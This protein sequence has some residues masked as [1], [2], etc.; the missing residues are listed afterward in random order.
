MDGNAF[1]WNQSDYVRIQAFSC[2]NGAKSTA[3]QVLRER[4]VESEI[5]FNDRLVSTGRNS[6]PP[7]PYKDIAL[8][9][10]LANGR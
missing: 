9:S 7:S 10:L 8:A 5:S 3:E 4:G 2:V 1:C 6:S